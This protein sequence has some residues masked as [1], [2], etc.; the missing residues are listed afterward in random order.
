LRANRLTRRQPPL[1]RRWVE[2]QPDIHALMQD[3]DDLGF[4]LV[5]HT[6]EDDMRPY[7]ES[8]SDFQDENLMS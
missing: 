6:K 7:G 5:R 2:L 3:A 4:A 8:N 1:V